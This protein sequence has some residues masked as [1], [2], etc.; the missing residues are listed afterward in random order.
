[1]R[2]VVRAVKCLAQSDVSVLVQGETGTGKE[3]I[4]RALHDLG[5]R[6]A[7]PY[8]IVDVGAL[9]PSLVA[10]QLFGHERGAFTGADSRQVGAFEQAQG[11]SILLDEVGELPAS[12]Q[13]ALLGVLERRTF[14][15]LGG[16]EEI[17][18][19]VRVIA[20]THRDLRAEVPRGT[21]RDDLYFRMAAA[22]ISLPPLRDRPEDILP[23]AEHFARQIGGPEAAG[24]AGPLARALQF[25]SWPGNVRELRNVVE[26]AL[27][28][29][30]L[31]PESVILEMS[32]A[33]RVSPEA[34]VPYRTA[35]EAAIGAFER[36]YLSCLMESA[37]GNAAAA[38]RLAR[39][40]RSYLLSLLRKL[41]IRGNGNGRSM[42]ANGVS[43][44]AEPVAAD[45]PLAGLAKE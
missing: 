6:A 8:V 4:A 20:A 44:P 25:H 26:Q 3:L 32:V 38:A 30:S 10:S 45:R 36:S 23:L 19:D 16:R 35:R 14:R 15:R 27:T 41:Q 39:M 34:V 40:D 12:V 42:S 17:R 37:G 1:M 43:I 31:A 9:A 28:T 11:G 29:G 13:P 21:F 5:P 33:D 24:A 18:A 7:G 2:E 22:R